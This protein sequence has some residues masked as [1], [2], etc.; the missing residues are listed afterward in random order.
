MEEQRYFCILDNSA[1]RET[2][3]IAQKRI[4][5]DFEPAH[6]SSQY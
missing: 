1:V 4:T 6:A 3:A 5:R 2:S